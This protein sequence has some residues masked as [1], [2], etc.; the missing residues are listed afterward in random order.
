MPKNWSHNRDSP[1]CVQCLLR[2]IPVLLCWVHSKQAEV[3][4][5]VTSEPQLP[6]FSV[7]P[8]LWLALNHTK[9]FLP[10]TQGRAVPASFGHKIEQE[11]TVSRWYTECLYENIIASLMKTQDSQKFCLAAS[12]AEMHSPSLLQCFGGFTQPTEVS[13]IFFNHFNSSGIIPPCTKGQGI[14]TWSP[15]QMQT[16][17]MRCQHHRPDCSKRP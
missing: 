4:T 11:N 1:S 14:S 3:S 13:T 8:K 10:P 6:E 7:I 5:D 9:E 15:G 12:T 17:K 2:I 16:G